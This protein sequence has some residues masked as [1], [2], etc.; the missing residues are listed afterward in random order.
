MVDHHPVLSMTHFQAAPSMGIVDVWKHNAGSVSYILTFHN[1]FRKFID[2]KVFYLFDRDLPSR[3]PDYEEVSVHGDQEDREGGE[4]D[5]GGLG[6]A[7][8]LAQDL[9]HEWTG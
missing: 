6:G 4:E 7:D 2:P 8:Q 5:A 3:G 1:I 9:L